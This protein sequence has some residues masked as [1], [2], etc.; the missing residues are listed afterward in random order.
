MVYIQKSNEFRL[1]SQ[2]S[3]KTILVAEMNGLKRFIDEYLL[4]IYGKLFTITEKSSTHFAWK[5]KKDERIH[6]Y[7]HIDV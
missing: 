1:V 2:P 3:G 4:P 6:G 7:F 5:S